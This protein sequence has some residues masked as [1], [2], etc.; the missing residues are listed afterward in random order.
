[1][2]ATK[3]KT[4]VAPVQWVSPMLQLPDSETSV[5]INTSDGEVDAGYY[6]GLW[7]WACAVRIEDSSVLYWAE[8]PEAPAV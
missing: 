1:M 8:M 7:R 5:L 3:P 4:H 6:D 2:T